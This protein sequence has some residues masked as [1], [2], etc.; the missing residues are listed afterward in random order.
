LER[1]RL[2]AP[3]VANH[4]DIAADAA[5]W[6]I[7]CAACEHADQHTNASAEPNTNS[8]AYSHAVADTFN[9]AVRASPGDLDAFEQ[10]CAGPNCARGADV[11]LRCVSADRDFAL[12]QRHCQCFVAG[13]R[14][15]KRAALEADL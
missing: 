1:V 4:D 2:S 13:A 3:D 8:C 6:N 7:I 12:G 11:E 9:N 10:R 15:R 5:H 14:C